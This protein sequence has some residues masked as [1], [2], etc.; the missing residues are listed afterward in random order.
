L[1]KADLAI[2]KAGERRRPATVDRVKKPF[3]C[4]G[5]EQNGSVINMT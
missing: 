5:L 4:M 1:I 3:K 2:Q